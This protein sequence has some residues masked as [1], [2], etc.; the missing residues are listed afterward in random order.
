MFVGRPTPIPHPNGRRRDPPGVVAP[1]QGPSGGRSIPLRVLT[2]GGPLRSTTR[3]CFEDRPERLSG[4]ERPRPFRSSR[5][6]HR[7]PPTN[8]PLTRSARSNA[9]NTAA[10]TTS[11][12]WPGG[13]GSSPGRPS[14]SAPKL[15]TASVVMVVSVVP[16]LIALTRSPPI[17]GWPTRTPP[18][19]ARGWPRHVRIHEGRRPR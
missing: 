3:W 15:G 18:R 7:P 9:R 4:K 16:G 6:G 12:G 10:L 11:S 2:S 1:R 19:L 13:R 5:R 14:W 17:R 8:S